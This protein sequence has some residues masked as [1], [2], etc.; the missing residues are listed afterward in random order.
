MIYIVLLHWNY[1]IFLYN[2]A[3]QILK[4]KVDAFLSEW[5][6]DKNRLP[7]I[8][9]GARQIGKTMSI[10]LFAK[11]NYKHV[12]EINFA[13]QQQ[14][15]SIFENGYEAD[16][17]IKAISLRNPHAL[18]VPDETLIFFDEIQACPKCATS[19]KSFALDG[20][21]DVIC[22]GSLMGINYQEIESVSV[23]YKQDYEMASLDF[24]E[25]LWACGYNDG[26]VSD[27][28]AHMREIR[29][30][31]DGEMKVFMNLFRDYM[32]VGGMPAVVRRFVE[33]R[34]FSGILQLQRQLL[35]DYE[36]DITK[37]AY[38]LDKGK[39]KQVYNHIPVFLGKENKKFQI[40]KIAT[41]ARSREYAGTVDW[42]N[43]AGIVNICYLLESPS[44]PLKGNY[45]PKSY[46]IYYRD[47]S[48]LIASLDE[49]SQED[50]RQ[51]LNFG[52]YRGAIYENIVGDML[53]KQGYYLYYYRN[54]K[55]TVEMDFFIRDKSSLIPI[56]VKANDHATL[57]L[58]HLV[59]KPQ[60]GDIKYGIKLC[61]KNIGFDGS[62]YTFP[63][64]LTFLLKRWLSER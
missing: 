56:E 28:L 52:T 10:N 14:F 55:S 15:L 2:K 20:R 45:S 33:N 61:Y 29:P 39:V 22:S 34:N 58:N 26:I 3:M 12:I 18:F 50:I 9:K 35:A 21:Y 13:L 5:K 25:F 53:V 38:G 48:L 46:K 47:T 1:V 24:E 27:M 59:S 62:F 32:V 51:N 42:L 36:E 43:D 4:R 31:A 41:G 60:Y 37:Y 44:L 17:V 63:Y 7:L 49:E 11:Q 64:F 19:L 23:G 30:F 8:V 57:S 16:E 54:E 40:T 6:Q